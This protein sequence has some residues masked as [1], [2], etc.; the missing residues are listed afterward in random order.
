MKSKTISSLTLDTA[1]EKLIAAGLATAFFY[2]SF[3]YPFK[4]TC[5][6][7]IL[8]LYVSLMFWH[9]QL[10]LFALPALIPVLDLAPWTGWFSVEEIDLLLLISAAFGY[11]HLGSDKRHARLSGFA[12]AC[13]S[14][15]SLAYLIGTYRGITPLALFDGNELNNYLSS[16]NSL[17]VGKSWFWMLLFLPLLTRALGPNL[18][19]LGGRLI[20]GMLA[21]LALVSAAVIVERMTFPGF[22]NFSSDYR[23]TAPFSAMHT[24]GAALDGFLSLSFPLVAA[25]LLKRQFNVNMFSA[26]VLLALA[27][28]AGL[29]TFSRGLYFAYMSTI[30]IIPALLLYKSRTLKHKTNWSAA[31]IITA[32]CIII[33]AALLQMFAKAGYRGFIAAMILLISAAIMPTAAITYRRVP[34]NLLLGIAIEAALIT[35]TPSMTGMASGIFKPPYLYF[36][37]SALFFIF[38]FFYCK[39]ISILTKRWIDVPFAVLICMSINMLWIGYHW[40]GVKTFGPGIGIIF[41]ALLLIGIRLS[42]HNILWP[43]DRNILAPIFTFSI[44]AILAIPIASSYFAL[45][46]FSHLKEDFQY[47]IRHW[48]Q[49]LDMMDRDY[50]TEIIGMGL[51]KFPKIYYWRNALHES[52][53]SFHYIEEIGNRYVRLT[54][55]IYSSGIGELL[56]LLQRV[57]ILEDREYILS[58]DIRNATNYIP[59]NLGVAL[60]ERQLLYS[61]N[62]IP[63]K[64]PA[65]AHDKLWHHYDVML[66]SRNLGTTPF[67]WRS[68]TSIEVAIEGENAAIDLDNISLRDYITNKELVRNGSFSDGSDYWFFSSDHHH[69]PWHIKNFTINIYFELG[70]LGV[71]A[72]YL[73]LLHALISLIFLARNEQRITIILFAA[74]FGFLV[75]GLTDSLLDVPRLALLFFLI[76]ISSVL[77]PIAGLTIENIQR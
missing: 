76:L 61:R 73:L 75:V 32:F 44:I 52:P 18:I 46:R 36:I 34:A 70:W 64:L 14:L 59:F 49:V 53:A 19:N 77:R 40:A 69:L 29:T 2:V 6:F 20:P 21:G 74:L 62:C 35:L 30:I 38:S 8:L 3:H 1:A 68:P 31:Y 4:A 51:G 22:F 26:L 45:D 54:A 13:I 50:I 55:P 17:R 56:R 43:S 58:I 41:L 12:V 5:L 72:L 71:I 39:P 57:P 66:N 7:P 63:A 11:W 67:L 10:W 16:W 23:I 15:L 48:S 25:Q 33:I 37:I 24:G 28:Y 47:R 27:G 65:I 9:H 60:C 42:T